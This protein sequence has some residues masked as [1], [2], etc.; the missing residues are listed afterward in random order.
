MAASELTPRPIQPQGLRTHPGLIPQAPPHAWHPTSGQPGTRSN[1][2]LAHQGSDVLARC[3]EC[4]EGLGGSED[5]AIPTVNA[6]GVG[7]AFGEPRPVRSDRPDLPLA[8]PGRD[9]PRGVERLVVAPDSRAPGRRAATRH[10]PD[11]QRD[12][13]AP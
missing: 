10:A 6:P 11:T 12:R 1:G 5:A 8:S 3:A 4:R 13:N 7:R 2:R 9:R